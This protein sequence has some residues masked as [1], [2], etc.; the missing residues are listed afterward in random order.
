MFRSAV[1]ATAK[2]LL[3]SIVTEALMRHVIDVVFGELHNLVQRTATTID[4]DALSALE[5]RID[6]DGL[7]KALASLLNARL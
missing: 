5:A 3:G 1:L 4:D 7:A 6:K 2:M